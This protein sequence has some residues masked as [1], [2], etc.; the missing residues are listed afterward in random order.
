MIAENREKKLGEFND[1]KAEQFSKVTK[2]VEDW[3]NFSLTP[4]T[5]D[6]I[7]E[8]ILHDNKTGQNTICITYICE[9]SKLS[10]EFIEE[11]C[12]LTKYKVHIVNTTKYKWT[13]KVDWAAISR[14]Q[15]L[16][17]EFIDKHKNEVVW[18]DIYANQNLSKE[19]ILNHK[20]NVLD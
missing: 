10:E 5:E 20:G 2:K 15:N 12:E 7:R 18:K 1:K 11:L 6:A 9:Y 17:E 4:Q 3:A 19:F 13:N 16:S 8:R 14:S